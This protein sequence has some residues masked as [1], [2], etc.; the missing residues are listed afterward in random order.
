M[1]KLLRVRKLADPQPRFPGAPSVLELPE[2]CFW[3]MVLSLGQALS[4]RCAFRMPLHKPQAAPDDGERRFKNQHKTCQIQNR[5]A[6]L[7]RLSGLRAHQARHPT[8]PRSPARSAT[9]AAPALP[10]ANARPTRPPRLHP[11]RPRPNTDQ[12]R[13]PSSPHR[14]NTRTRSLRRPP[15]S[16]Q[17]KPRLSWPICQHRR[18]QPCRLRFPPLRWPKL[19][20]RSVQSPANRCGF[21]MRHRFGP[22]LLSRNRCRS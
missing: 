16:L 2:V 6:P 9:T 4:A 15:W 21:P 18:R 10:A 7:P 20:P 5:P 11:P 14:P 8:P 17:L 12:P 3:P 1:R 19:P 22:D 13:C